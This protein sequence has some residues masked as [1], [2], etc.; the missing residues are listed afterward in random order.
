[1]TTTLTTRVEIRSVAPAIVAALRTSDDSGRRPR[2]TVDSD[3]GAPMR[4]CLRLSR[5]GERLALVSYAPLRRWALETG[6]DPGPYDEVGPVFIHAEECD[7]HPAGAMPSE[8]FEARRMFRKYDS[9]GAILGGRM[10]EVGESP[11]AVADEI[12]GSEPDV[13]L[14]HVR[15]VEFGCFLFELRRSDA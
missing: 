11:A 5:P 9:S 2:V 14:I 15:A 13:A 3:G 4:C 10:V 8:L 7:G 6:G 1:M 12:F